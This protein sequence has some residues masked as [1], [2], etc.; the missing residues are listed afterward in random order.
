MNTQ[1]NS[2]LKGS[3]QVGNNVEF[4]TKWKDIIKVND[5]KRHCGT[6]VENCTDKQT[7]F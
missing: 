2:N 3:Q 4:F 5:G 6:K 1:L 7:P